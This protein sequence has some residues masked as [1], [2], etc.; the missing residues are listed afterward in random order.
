MHQ[1]LAILKKKVIYQSVHRGTKEADSIFTSFLN[2]HVEDFS[3]FELVH[4]QKLLEEADN[5]IFIWL[6]YPERAPLHVTNNPV[7]Q[8]LLKQYQ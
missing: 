8:M 7:F 6:N 2:T 5:D 3:Y 1:E 4:Y